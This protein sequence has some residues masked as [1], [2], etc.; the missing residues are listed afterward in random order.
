MSAQEHRWTMER[1]WKPNF[2]FWAPGPEAWN[3]QV[4]SKSAM[5]Q[6]DFKKGQ[7]R[8]WPGCEMPKYL[9]NWQ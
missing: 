2:C 3:F 1:S 4:A 8:T 5:A 6:V 7:L 9:G